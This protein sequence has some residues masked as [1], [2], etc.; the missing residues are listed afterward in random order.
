MKLLGKPAA[1][2]DPSTPS[3]FR[4]IALTSCVGKLFTTILRNRWLSFMLG[5]KYLNR[6]VQKAFMPKTPGCI[7]HHHMLAEVFKDAK[8]KHKS[9]AVCWLDLANA[10]G[11]VNH[12]LILYSLRHY[13]APPQF[14]KLIQAF[15]SNLCC[16]DYFPPNGTPPQFHSRE[17]CIRV[18][19]FRWPFL[20]QS[21]TPWSTQS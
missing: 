11:S 8:K 1:M 4:P 12:S 9:L 3:N 16:Y 17:V 14:L 20:I 19:P 7:E 10:Y 21:S 6:S 15:Y 2:D 5:N 18:I 13:H